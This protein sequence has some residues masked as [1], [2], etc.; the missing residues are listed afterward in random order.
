MDVPPF[1]ATFL[2]VLQIEFEEIKKQIVYACR[3]EIE[4]LL[5]MDPDEYAYYMTDTHI[6]M[7]SRGPQNPVYLKNRLNQYTTEGQWKYGEKVKTT[8]AILLLKDSG[9]YDEVLMMIA[10]E[11]CIKGADE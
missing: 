6:R 8:Y 9:M 2:P 7:E 5:E 11:K 3:P 1:T 4:R 10:D